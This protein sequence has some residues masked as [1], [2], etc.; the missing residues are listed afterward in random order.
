[1]L[2]SLRRTGEVKLN[3]GLFLRPVLC[4]DWNR[5][6]HLGFTFVTRFQQKAYVPPH[7]Q[8]NAELGGLFSASRGPMP[9]ADG[10][11]SVTGMAKPCQSRIRGLH[12]LFSASRGPSPSADGPGHPRIQLFIFLALKVQYP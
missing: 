5:C 4:F 2:G 10:L 9:S 8:I 7:T 11:A 3:G 12:G 6:V 1:M